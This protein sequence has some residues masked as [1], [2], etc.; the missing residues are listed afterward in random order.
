[1]RVL[2]TGATGFIGREL[3]PLLLASGAEVHTLGR[4]SSGHA[5]AIHHPADLLDNVDATTIRAIGATHLIHLAW[6]TEPGFWDAPR[7]LDWMAA[8]IVLVRAFAHGGGQRAVVAGSCAEYDWTGAGRL[9]EANSPIQPATLYGVA[10]AGLHSVLAKAA[11]QLGL[12][13]AW[14]R[15]FFPYGP[16][17]RP[18]RLLGSLLAAARCGEVARVSDGLQRRDFIHVTDVAAAVF[19]IAASAAE[20]PLNV[21][22]GEAVAVRRFIEIVTQAAGSADRVAYGAIP[23]RADDPPL[24]EGAIDRL[25]SETDYRP[26][27]TLINGLTDAVARSDT[28]AGKGIR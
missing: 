8:S 26:R 3:V 18:E 23:S 1:M 9:D 14:A 12:S 20:G 2:V 17:E 28:G 4:S 21:A 16:G 10:K 15:I 25:L 5:S 24:I 22:S 11:P 6:T 19:A 13:L 7:N 27:F